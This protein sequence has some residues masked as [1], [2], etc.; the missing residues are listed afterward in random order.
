M[1]HFLA[2]LSLDCSSMRID[3]SYIRLFISYSLCSDAIGSS[4]AAFRAGMPPAKTPTINDKLNPTAI[5]HNGTINGNLKTVAA[6]KANA[7]PNP[8]PINNKPVN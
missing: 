4:L 7:T 3:K 2:Y 5:D 8:T 6:L 1:D